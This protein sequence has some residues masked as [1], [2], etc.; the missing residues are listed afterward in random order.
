MVKEIRKHWL[1]PNAQE[2]CWFVGPMG[3]VG[4]PRV[5]L[6]SGQ[7]EKYQ[8]NPRRR[9]RTIWASKAWAPTKLTGKMRAFVFLIGVPNPPS[10]NTNHHS[11]ILSFERT[12]TWGWVE[13]MMLLLLIKEQSIHQSILTKNPIERGGVTSSIQ[14]LSSG[15]VLPRPVLSCYLPFLTAPPTKNH[16]D[17]SLSRILIRLRPLVAILLL[18]QPWSDLW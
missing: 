17:L 13:G 12:M 6:W 5:R 11:T 7:R 8:S 4:G 3:R 10:P 16:F 14:T 2:S 9:S 1:G 15:L 18:L